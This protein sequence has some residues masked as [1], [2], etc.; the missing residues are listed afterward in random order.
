V[1]S[2]HAKLITVAAQSGGNPDDNPSLYAAVYK[3]K[4]E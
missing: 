3:A 2:I 4:K 1:F